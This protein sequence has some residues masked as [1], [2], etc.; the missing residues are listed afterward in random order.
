MATDSWTPGCHL[1]SSVPETTKQLSLTVT[2]GAPAGA[3]SP[4][5][6]GL[7]SLASFQSL[8]GL[9]TATSDCDP[10]VSFF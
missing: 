8:E 5:I 9:L 7:Q 1:K 10:E 3:T 6:Q 2:S 4:S